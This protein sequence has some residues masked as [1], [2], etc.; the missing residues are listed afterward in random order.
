M[1]TPWIVAVD[2]TLD[3]FRYPPS[4]CAT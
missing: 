3:G 4:S 2:G 1:R